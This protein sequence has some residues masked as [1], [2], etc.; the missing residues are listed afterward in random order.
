MSVDVKVMTVDD[1]LA[2]PSD[3]LATNYVAGSKLLELDETVW[4]RR[5][6]GYANHNSVEVL[7]AYDN[8]LIL[9]VAF[10]IWPKLSPAYM[11]SNLRLFHSFPG[12]PVD[13]N[14]Y[15]ALLST[16]IEKGESQGRWEFYMRRNLDYGRWFNRR[17]QKKTYES[18]PISKKYLRSIEEIIPANTQSK[19]V[20]TNTLCNNE[21]VSED[22]II[23][24]YFCPQSERSLDYIPADMRAEHEN[25]I[26]V[27]ALTL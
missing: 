9:G 26:N 19:W 18:I 20:A 3:L 6:I 5:A 11:I 27:L 22:T 8:D 2:I 25:T 1:I 13:K 12:F 14:G 24:K 21:I 17:Y 4:K 10:V 16:A 15:G 7:G 23:V